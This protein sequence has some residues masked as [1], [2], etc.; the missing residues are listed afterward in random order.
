VT[1]N[2]AR[3]GVFSTFCTAG[4]NDEKQTNTAHF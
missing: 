4:E 1:P 2:I 3:G